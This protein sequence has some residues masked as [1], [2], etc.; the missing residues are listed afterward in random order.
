M[1]SFFYH[2]PFIYLSF[3]LLYSEQQHAQLKKLHFLASFVERVWPCDCVKGNEIDISQKCQMGVWKC[4]LKGSQLNL[5]DIYLYSFLLP[6]TSY[7]KHD[8]N[9][10]TSSIHPELFWEPS[11]RIVTK[12]G[13]KIQKSPYQPWIAL[14]QT[15]FA[16]SGIN[17]SCLIYCYFG[18][19]CSMQPS[20]S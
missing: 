4:I 7:L 12:K 5:E 19:S 14:F 17:S 16:K 8:W 20:S 18:F 10:W 13:R 11:T 9:G 6:F 2:L 15:P 3:F 1:A